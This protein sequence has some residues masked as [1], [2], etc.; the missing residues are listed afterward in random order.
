MSEKNFSKKFATKKE[1]LE[2]LGKDVED[3]KL[4]DRMIK[5]GDIKKVDGEY[6]LIEKED[7]YV[8]ITEYVN[9]IKELENKIFELE[10][11]LDTF[12]DETVGQITSEDID[13]ISAN[14]EYREK[15]AK[16]NWKA[17][18]LVID[19]VYNKVSPMLKG[20]IEEREE[21]KEAILD[22][23]REQLGRDE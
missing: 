4:I 23:V 19:M 12:R 9:K 5:R 17:I 21:F 14:L 6:Q 15:K 22:A 8:K 1:I 18:Y 13:R 11:E 2:Y 16:R 20:R 3:R 10:L 7:P